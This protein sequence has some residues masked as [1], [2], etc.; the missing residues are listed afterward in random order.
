MG[1]PSNDVKY[2]TLDQAWEMSANHGSQG[3]LYGLLLD[4]RRL[5][6]NT[7]S[8]IKDGT[9]LNWEGLGV[10]EDKA[11]E[12]ASRAITELVLLGASGVDGARAIVDDAREYQK[13]D[14]PS[15]VEPDRSLEEWILL[16]E[17]YEWRYEH[18]NPVTPERRLKYMGIIANLALWAVQAARGN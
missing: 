2:L 1:R 17:E 5:Y 14:W 18:L 13:K 7:P 8:Y 4:L 12:V 16:T 15:L 3:S 6:T 10:I 9:Q 11:A